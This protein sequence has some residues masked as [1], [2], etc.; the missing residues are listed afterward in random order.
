MRMPIKFTR[1]MIRAAL[2]GALDRVAYQKDPIFN[3]EVPASCPD[4]PTELLQPCASWADQ[5]AYDRQAASVARMFVDN[6]S[7]A[8][9]SADPEV[10]AAGPTI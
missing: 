4:V 1:A 10:L 7:A 5:E 8:A 2:A 6:F 3:V 9:L